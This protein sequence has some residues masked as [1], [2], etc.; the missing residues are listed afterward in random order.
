MIETDDAI[1]TE[2]RDGIVHVHFKEGLE[3]T[4]E[5]QGRLF[6]VYNEICEGEKK[7]FLFTASEHVSVTK[8]ARENAIVMQGLFPGLASAVLV[9]S[10]GYKI[11]ANFYLKVNKPTTPYQVFSKEEEAIKW[12]QGFLQKG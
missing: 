2:I 10:L 7:P 12:L 4:V 8:S 3:I 5:V 1:F 9:Q 11:I 6:D